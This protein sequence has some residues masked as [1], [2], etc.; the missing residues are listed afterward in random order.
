MDDKFRYLKGK[1]LSSRVHP[2]YFPFNPNDRVIN[3]G[4]GVGPQAIVYSG[5][6]K[7]MIGIDINKEKLKK[8][9]EAMRVFG[10]HNY[11]TL[12]ANVQRIPLP[13]S[14]FD[15][16]IAIDVIEHVKNPKKLCLEINR[17]LKEDGEL[18][19]TFP[20]MHDS[21][22][23]FVSKVEGFISKVKDFILRRKRR[24]T[25]SS[26]NEW[27][28]DDHNQ[29]YPL[30]EWVAIVEDCGFKLCESRAST[31]FPPLHLYGIH[32]FW[33]SN[34]IIHKIDTFLCK[35]PFLK[36]YGQAL[37]CIFKEV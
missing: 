23:G 28:P 37:V 14:S 13:D 35:T 25:R 30:D 11:T 29:E 7:E 12:C 4:C 10:V 20:A 15:K 24:E 36:N 22:T 9:E 18:L 27:N 5:Q 31:L 34:D 6:Y 17:L 3:L 26:S 21:F 16:A 8:S 32:R 19:I 2:E 1:L 33:Y